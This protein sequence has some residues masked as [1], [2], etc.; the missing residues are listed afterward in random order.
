MIYA[1][2]IR[3]M[4]FGIQD[5]ASPLQEGII[6][7]HHDLMVV[8]I[9]VVVFV[10]VILG[11]ALYFFNEKKNKVSKAIVHGTVI[12]IVW[13]VIPALVLMM[14]AI[15]SFT[16]L[17]AVDEVVDPSLTVKV[18]GHQWYWSY[19]LS[20]IGDGVEFDS[21]MVAEEDLGD[22]ELRLLEV[23][24]RLMI[25][26]ETHVRFIVTA[27]DVLHCFAVPSFGVKI[28]ACPGRLNEVST[29]VKRPGVFYGQCSELCGVNHSFMPI[30]IEVVSMER[31]LEWLGENLEL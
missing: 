23:D 17:Y 3:E 5:P 16:L 28:D 7:F 9:F 15:P 14:I 18:V 27:A 8:M 6:N 25:P 24:N 1:D 31:Y 26:V 30:C 2:G 29:F 13:T 11:R 19:E 10:G 21:Y 12:E 22:G 4:Q 20:D